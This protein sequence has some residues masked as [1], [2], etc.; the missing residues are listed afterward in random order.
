[1][2]KRSLKPF[3]ANG[4]FRPVGATSEFRR[5]AVRSAGV[6]VLSQGVVYGTQ[7]IATVVL[8][9]LLAPS[10]F[11]VVTMV[12]T[13]SLLL[14][15]FGQNGYAEAVIQRAEMDHLLASNLFWINVGV[16]LLLAIGFAAAGSVLARFYGDLR[17]AQVTVWI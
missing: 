3:D 7:M 2:L 6:T 12:T 9:R 16:G 17:V 1:M 5:R 8:A 15:S 4:T 10:D 11:G 14:M 13:F